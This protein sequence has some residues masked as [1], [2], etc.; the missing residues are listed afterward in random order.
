[1][2]FTFL[3]K[4]ET[5]GRSHPQ[6][7]RC[8]FSFPQNENTERLVIVSGGLGNSLPRLQLSCPRQLFPVPLL[9]CTHNPRTLLPSANRSEGLHTRP[10]FC[11]CARTSSADMI[12]SLIK[13]S[14]TKDDEA[15]LAFSSRDR[16]VATTHFMTRGATFNPKPKRVKQYLLPRK[17]TV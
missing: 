6:T 10:C 9:S 17:M 3:F 13:I 5:A 4:K 12:S 14:S 11:K 2:A 8:P 7:G 1:M 16:A 15:W